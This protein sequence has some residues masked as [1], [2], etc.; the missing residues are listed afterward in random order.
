MTQPTHNSTVP[1]GNIQLAW[2]PVP[3]AT[4]YEYFVSGGG[5]S[6][7][8]V[9]PGLIVQVP[10]AA[11]GGAPTAYTGIVRSCP[12]GASCAPGSDAGWGPWSDVAGPGVTN[13]TV[14]P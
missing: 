4:L 3:G 11:V 12:A 2:S 10:L 8:G 14:T 13:F 9:T 6:T 1:A 5:A 7:R